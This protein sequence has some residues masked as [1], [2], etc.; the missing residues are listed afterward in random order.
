MALNRIG[1][2]LGLAGALGVLLAA[3]MIT[4]QMTSSAAVTAANERADRAQLVVEKTL[5]AALNMRLT[6]LGARSAR[7]AR[8]LPEVEKA[9]EEVRTYSEAQVRDLDAALAVA[10]APE[11]VERLNKLKSLMAAY[12]G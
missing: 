8:T 7:L 10:K 2:K 5:S 1:N 12:I 3:G 11:S 9:V 6:Q 4:N